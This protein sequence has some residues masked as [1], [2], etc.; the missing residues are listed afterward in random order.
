M[1]SQHHGLLSPQSLQQLL[2]Q[3]SP[4]LVVSLCSDA[5]RNSCLIP[6]A[7]FLDYKQL[8]R[9]APPALALLPDAAALSRVFSQLGLTPQRDV[10]AYDDEGGARA[11]RLLWTLDTC[12]HGGRL[13]LLDGGAQAWRTAGFDFVPA[14]A[15]PA[16]SNYPVGD[17]NAAHADK[18]YILSHLNNGHTQILDS[19]SEAEYDGSLPRANRNGHIPGAINVE[20]TTSMQNGPGKPLKALNEI[21]TIFDRAGLD[22]ANEIIVHCHSHHRS[23]HSYFVLK[24]LGYPKVRAYSGSWS[25]WGNMA[26]TPIET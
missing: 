11:C 15:T 14:A 23:A 25:E 13:L 22:P 21:Q 24:L 8:V 19:R 12:G 6:G 2:Q 3:P 26:D 17:S 16:P 1:S 20:W 18:N 9:P 5:G 4:P 10:V 7:V